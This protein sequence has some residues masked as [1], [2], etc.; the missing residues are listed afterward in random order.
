MVFGYMFSGKYKEAFAGKLQRWN[1]DDKTVEFQV[2]RVRGQSFGLPFQ[3]AKL[4]ANYQKFW[5][6]Y[7]CCLVV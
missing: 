2:E 7:S 3:N 4:K 6:D 1:D 5:L